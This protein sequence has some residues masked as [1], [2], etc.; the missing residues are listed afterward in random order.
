[1]T[2]YLKSPRLEAV[3]MLG[4]LG[5]SSVALLLLSFLSEAPT[6]GGMS[7]TMITMILGGFFL[8]SFVIAMI[9]AMSGIGG[10]G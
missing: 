9:A 3:I 2:R 5:I 7:T 6:D 10:L 1:M 4:I 8:L